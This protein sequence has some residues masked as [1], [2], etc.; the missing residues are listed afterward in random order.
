MHQP[1]EPKVQTDEEEWAFHI[2][3]KH[4]VS[5]VAQQ[6][7]NMIERGQAVSF[8]IKLR[9]PKLEPKTSALIPYYVSCINQ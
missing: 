6:G 1:I 4:P 2:Y 5:R 8:T 3:F 7:Q 9:K